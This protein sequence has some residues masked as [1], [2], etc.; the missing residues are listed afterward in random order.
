MMHWL[1]FLI[2]FCRGHEEERERERE[3]GRGMDI[4]RLKQSGESK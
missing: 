1:Y 3:W 4:R 2:V